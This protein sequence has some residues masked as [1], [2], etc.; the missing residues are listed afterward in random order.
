[1]TMMSNPVTSINM[2][3]HTRWH[4]LN[5]TINGYGMNEGVSTFLVDQ[6]N[7]C[8]RLLLNILVNQMCGESDDM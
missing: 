7:E 3:S 1:M 4:G 5:Y 8:Q 2:T 6:A